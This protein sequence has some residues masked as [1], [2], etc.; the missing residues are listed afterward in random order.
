LTA[1]LLALGCFF[2]TSRRNA[3]ILKQLSRLTI[4]GMLIFNVLVI[5]QFYLCDL[6]LFRAVAYDF[7]DE[8]H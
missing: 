1:I 7:P 5:A 3:N 8:D 2:S 4:L 6:Y